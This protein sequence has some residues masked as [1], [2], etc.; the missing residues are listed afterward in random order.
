VTRWRHSAGSIPDPRLRR[1]ALTKLAEERFNIEVAATLA[2]L[3]PRACRAA[4]VEATVALQTAYDHLDLLTEGPTFA[5]D[6]GARLLSGLATA[7][8]TERPATAAGDGG[9]LR[10]LLHTV[11]VALTELPSAARVLAV[12]HRSAERCA[13]AQALNHASAS[14]LG[15][16]A[17]RRWAMQQAQLSP[18]GWR[19]LA[20]GATASVL[21]IHALIAAAAQGGTYAS[22]AGALEKLYLMIG[23]LTMLDSLLDQEAD[24]ATG[25]RSWPSRYRDEHEMVEALTGTA[26]RARACALDRP[27]GAHHLITLGGV[28]AYY[29]S[30]RPAG[31]RKQDPLARGLR[32]ELGATLDAPMLVMRLW[33]LAKTIRGAGASCGTFD[34]RSLQLVSSVGRVVRLRFRGAGSERPVGQVRR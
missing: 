26:A 34:H 21:C 17:F 1:A 5:G 2:T 4:T 31:L 15:E 11:Q 9:Y 23:A 27:D 29:A 33:R 20:A 6:G 7:M 18:L 25:A 10:A 30:A 13:Q 12:A 14:A 32:T 28:V 24:Q 16:Q 3:A 19:E 8:S 22:D